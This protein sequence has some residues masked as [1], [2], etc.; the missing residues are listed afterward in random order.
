MVCPSRVSYRT[1][2]QAPHRLLIGASLA[3]VA[4]ASSFARADEEATD[5]WMAVFIGGRK[6][7]WM[8]DRVARAEEDGRIVWVTSSEQCLSL[9]RLGAPMTITQKSMVVEDADGLVLRFSSATEQGPTLMKS[10]GIVT[11]GRVH[12]TKNAGTPSEFPFPGGALG[13]AAFERKLRESGVKAGVAVS[14]IRFQA[15]VPDKAVMVKSVVGSEERKDVLGRVLH[16]FRVESTDS[17]VK[18]STTAWVDAQ[19]RGYAMKTVVPG[20]GEMNCYATAEAIAKANV[21]PAEI[22]AQTEIEPD[23]VIGKPRELKK[24]TYRI[25]K[26]SG[27]IEGLYE[28]EGQVVLDRKSGTISLSVEPWT[29]SAN[30]TAAMRPLTL[31][32]TEKCLA[33]N[34]YLETSDSRVRKFASEAVGDETDA[35]KCARLIEAYVHKTISKKDFNVGFATAAETARSCEGDCSEHGVLCAALARAVG[36]PSRVVTGV[37]YLSPEE[38]GGN[39]KPHGAFGFHMWAEVLVAEGCWMPIDAAI[40][41][42]D[43]THIA[44]VKSDLSSAN[45]EVEMGLVVLEALGSIRIEVIEAR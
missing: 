30:F 5:E 33:A 7:G 37:V 29:P 16:L 24:A 23:R 14:L 6:S 4:A 36:L 35:V 15:E 1:S 2:M 18:L 26:K 32:G 27:A 20:L 40:G 10:E 25:A 3:V 45:P 42:F 38:M 9:S 22:F 12:L 34:A 39:P 43:A 13:P 31:P 19:G 8:H 41:V 21:Q 17:L 28:G 44:F 11:D